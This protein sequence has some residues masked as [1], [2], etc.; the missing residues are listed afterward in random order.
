[1]HDLDR[2]QAEMEAAEPETDSFEL[3]F[4][5][6]I[7][8]D[9]ESRLGGVFDEV[10]EMELASQLLEVQ[11]ESE[12]EEFLGKLIKKAARA[13]GKFISSPAGKALGGI[14]K[15]AAKKLLPIAGTALG[16]LVGGPAGAALGGNLAGM[17]GKA[18]GLELEG[19][20]QEDQEFEV[21]RQFVRF[22]GEAAKNAA[23]APPNTPPDVAANNGT[24]AAAKKHA[25]GLLRPN[26]GDGPR[27]RRPG[28]RSGRWMRRGNTI[29]LF[30][31]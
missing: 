28:A 29:V 9:G 3:E 21:A 16:T 14:L 1:M 7:S 18:L 15:G 24:V 8:S 17:A 6:G 27:T 20:S 31:V 4:E 23:T 22:A 2:T 19:L 30:G 13:A 26:G 10:D 5:G 11:D 12:M 25:P